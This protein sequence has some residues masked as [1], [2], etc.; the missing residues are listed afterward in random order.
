MD[1]RKWQQGT[2]G[3]PIRR[4]L[5]SHRSVDLYTAQKKNIPGSQ[6]T[7]QRCL[8]KLIRQIDIATETPGPESNTNPNSC[9]RSMDNTVS[10]DDHLSST[11]LQK[12]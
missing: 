9:S 2:F 11:V 12:F 7:Q 1:S 5:F 3:I 8:Q 6:E 10:T 4:Q